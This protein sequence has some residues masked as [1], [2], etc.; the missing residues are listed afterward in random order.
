MRPRPPALVPLLA[1]AL[2]PVASCADPPTDPVDDA[3]CRKLLAAP[4]SQDAYDWLKTSPLLKK[5]GG[6]TTEQALALAHTFELAGA[7][8]LTA[9]RVRALGPPGAAAGEASEGV[10]VTLPAEPA[11]RLA[12]FRLYAKQLRNY[13]GTPRADAGQRFLY[14]PWTREPSP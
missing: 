6:M 8:R 1:L 4:E 12:I 2:V 11:A 14:V 10:V 9:V 3:A 5:P 13:G 7:A